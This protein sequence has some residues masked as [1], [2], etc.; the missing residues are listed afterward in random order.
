MK[1]LLY[2]SLILIFAGLFLAACDEEDGRTEFGGPFYVELNATSN[3]ISE[4]SSDVVRIKVNNVG[5]TLDA[6]VVVSYSFEGSTA[7]EGED[8]EV[9]G[10]GTEG[11]IVIPAGANTG[12]ISL[13]M[14]P[15]LEVDGDKTYNV[16]LTANN[17]GLEVGR[18][19]IG[20][21]Y[22]LTII[23]DDCPIDLAGEYAGDWEV[24]SFCAAPGSFNDGFCV[25][26]QEGTIAT[27]SA[28]ASDPLGF[29]AIMSG[30]MHDDDMIINF[31]TC[32]QTVSISG[33]YVMAFT[34]N[35]APATMSA[36]DE[37]DVYGT[38]T[39]NP[40][41]KVITVVGVYGNTAGSSFDDFII[42]YT[43][44]D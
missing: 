32:P 34:Q 6:D 16:T 36:T 44:V 41:S 25:G 2:S 27:L 23:D 9:L 1:K 30:G 20:L 13:K 8:F 7:V 33:T 29:T 38:G 4:S 39:Y 19:Q 3:T 10:N 42:E 24:T 35:G 40:D 21:N 31:Q 11:Q 22:T 43:K 12:E 26:S 28:D 17:A 18:G 14:I 15:N 37:P 5:P